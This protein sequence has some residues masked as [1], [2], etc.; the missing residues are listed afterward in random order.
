MKYTIR[1]LNKSEYH[2]LKDFTYEA[3]FQRD[4][5]NL[6]PRDVLDEPSLRVFYED[7]GKPDDMCL[8]AETDGAPIA[9]AWTRI[10]AGE[11]RGFGNIDPYTPEFAISVYSAY[12]GQGIGTALM[13][14][15]LETL[16]TRGYKQTSL[17][18][19]KD[20][21]A[22]RLYENVGFQILREMDEEYLMVMD[23]TEEGTGY[24]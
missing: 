24:E 16:R 15:M 23:L 1:P 12:R 2:L 6:I 7:F 18:V 14:Q 5:D 20:N 17:A 13:E 4:P 9:A 3:V 10:L 8:V 22:V 11:P 21:Y 19:Q